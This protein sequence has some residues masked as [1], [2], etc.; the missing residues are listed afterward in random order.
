MALTRE[1]HL[2]RLQKFARERFDAQARWR[3]RTARG[4]KIP[5]VKTDDREYFADLGGGWKIELTRPKA[6]EWTVRLYAEWPLAPLEWRLVDLPYAH[7][8]SLA[9]VMVR[10][11]YETAGFL[12]TRAKGRLNGL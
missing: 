11:D 12:F 8:R 5:W 1:E 3:E 9:A 6:H 4:Y 10:E 7:A 2:A